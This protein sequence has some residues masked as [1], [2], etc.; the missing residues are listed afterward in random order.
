M[1]HQHSGSQQFPVLKKQL[2]KSKENQ[3]LHETAVAA[4]NEWEL[5]RRYFYFAQLI[6][7]TAGSVDW[8]Q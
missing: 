7:I 2:G 3:K 6:G 4:I 8:Y 5:C 1:Q